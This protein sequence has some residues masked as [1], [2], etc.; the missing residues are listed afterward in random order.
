MSSV[1]AF[2]S[3]A[4]AALILVA[5]QFASRSGA[6]APSLSSE[7]L[8]LES[9]QRQ[10]VARS[11]LLAAQDSA[12]TASREMAVAAG[13]LPD[14]VLRLGIDNLPTDG[15]DRFSI[16]RD[17]MTMRRIGVVQELTGGQ[18]RQL[19]SARL[20]LDAAKTLGER[21]A[22][23]ANIQRDTAIAWLD[24][25]YAEAMRAVVS[26]QLTHAKS[27]IEASES[28]YRAGRGT[29][30]DILA[31]YS[32]QVLIE[33][34]GSELARRVSGAK[35]NLARWLGDA[36]QAPLAGRPPLD[37][38]RLDG[39]AIDDQIGHHPQLALLAT[40]EDIARTDIQLAEANKKSDWTVELSYAQ[41]GSSYSNMMS[42]GLSVPLQWDQPNR[43]NR[44]VYAK[45]AL[46]DQA[47]AQKEDA[48]R[49]HIAEARAMLIDWQSGRE[50]QGRLQRELIPLASE[51]T[52]ALLGGYRAGK[53]G[54]TEVLAGRRNELDVRLQALQL[55]ADTAR[56][57][58]QLNF[59][60]PDDQVTS[61]HSRYH[62]QRKD[63]K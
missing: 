14:P 45:Q 34:R 38:V 31:A 58:A 49:M 12:I 13:Q 15:A 57:W 10:A 27:E 7:P 60:I 2:P 61:P 23:I 11:S 51:R 21:N 44:E 63:V 32:A 56:L 5:L 43:Q 48:L 62:F 18:K 59:L 42:V 30:A 8:T 55:E 29:S 20:E 28:A 25:Y 17:F 39:H 24:R 9:A 46:L 33:D 6:E 40:Q 47:R 54:L 16:G 50:R 53:L 35:S 52:E 22:A 36:A 26:T 19:R 3:C 37:S 4:R 41:R 1:F